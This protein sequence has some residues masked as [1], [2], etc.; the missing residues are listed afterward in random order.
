MKFIDYL[1]EE[2]VARIKGSGGSCEVFS[3]P[4][5]KE[6]QSI[7]YVRFLYIRNALY[8][9]D[10]NHATHFEVIHLKNI[11]ANYTYSDMTLWGIGRVKAGKIYVDVSGVNMDWGSEM[12]FSSYYKEDVEP[13][14]KKCKNYF[15]NWQE[16]YNYYKKKINEEYAFG[17][18]RYKDY[19]EVFKN[20]SSSEI[21]QFQDFIRFIIIDDNL[22]VWNADFACHNDVIGQLKRNY[23]DI[24]L[25]GVAKAQG[26]R[27][28]VETG[29]DLIFTKRDVIERI[30]KLKPYFNNFDL[31][32]SSLK[33]QIGE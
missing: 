31:V 18:K 21:Q 27:L 17:F 33:E 8:A 16:I 29:Y 14:L 26:N 7:E 28:K 9:F 6:L 22:Y 24:T 1:Q 3:W 23:H 2:Y 30:Q 10:A 13:A 11:G 4:T 19:C 12:H 15:Y 32:I 20:P 5:A 25:G